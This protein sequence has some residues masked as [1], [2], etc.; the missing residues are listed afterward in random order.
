MRAAQILHG[1]KQAAHERAR[2]MNG[3]APLC[4][5]AGF[6]RPLLWGL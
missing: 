4:E 6:I 1:A 2:L 3:A 5:G